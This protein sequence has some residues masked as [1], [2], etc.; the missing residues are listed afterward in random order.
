MA[1]AKARPAIRAERPVS[2]MAGRLQDWSVMYDYQNERPHVFTDAGQRQFLQVRDFCRRALEFSEAVSAGK[3]MSAAGSGDSWK[4]MACVDR[5]VELGEIREV[6]KA[7]NAWQA[8]IF[9]A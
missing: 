1:Q 2:Q 7:G 9:T 8:R 6:G 3:L 5:L 4:M